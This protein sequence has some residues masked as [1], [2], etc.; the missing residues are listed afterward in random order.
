MKYPTSHLYFLGIQTHLKARVYTQKIQ[1]TH[2]IPHG[3][4]PLKSITCLV[5]CPRVG[6]R[7]EAL[8]NWR[9]FRAQKKKKKK[10]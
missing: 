5:P 10:N 7:A 9:I 1:V 3:T 8:H 2:G 6:D 4:V